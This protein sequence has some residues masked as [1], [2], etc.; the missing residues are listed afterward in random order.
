MLDFGYLGTWLYIAIVTP[1]V[2]SLWLT[3]W[4]SRR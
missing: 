3:V 1:L 2:F 4:M